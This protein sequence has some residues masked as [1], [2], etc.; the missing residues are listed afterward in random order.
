MKIAARKGK[1]G[2]FATGT[3]LKPSTV[4]DYAKLSEVVG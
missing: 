4:V 3:P 2:A 1:P